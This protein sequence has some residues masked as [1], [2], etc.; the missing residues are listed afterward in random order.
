MVSNPKSSRRV[1]S[2]FT[3]VVEFCLIV[4]LLYSVLL[5]REF[6]GVNIDG[7][8]LGLAFQ[9]VLTIANFEIAIISGLV[10]SIVLEHV[11]RRS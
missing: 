3:F 7:K 5:M 10:G 4:F 6:T 11:K 1:A 8:T 9:N 2:I